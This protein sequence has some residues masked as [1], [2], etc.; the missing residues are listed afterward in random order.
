MYVLHKVHVA[1]GNSGSL[2]CRD[3]TN[4]IAANKGTT[5]RCALKSWS[6]LCAENSHELW[7]ACQPAVYA[8]SGCLQSHTPLS[9]WTPTI[10]LGH[11]GK[12][13]CTNLNGFISNLTC[14]I[15]SIVLIVRPHD[16]HLR[17][18]LKVCACNMSHTSHHN[19]GILHIMVYPEA[20]ICGCITFIPVQLLV[21]S[22]E[23]KCLPVVSN[24]FT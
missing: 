16:C 21:S 15:T 6:H 22:K 5:S 11:H 8:C 24:T 19:I 23:H 20:A 3:H 4:K 17:S 9:P 2:R 14:F 10:L 1:S 18:I 13:S 7:T 12:Q